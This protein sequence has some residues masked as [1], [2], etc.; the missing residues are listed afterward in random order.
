M[1][2]VIAAVIDRIEF[3]Q[4][5]RFACRSNARALEKLKAA[6]AELEARTKEREVRDVE[7]THQE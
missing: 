5:S 4:E 2:D 7:G 3:Y 6:L 1:E